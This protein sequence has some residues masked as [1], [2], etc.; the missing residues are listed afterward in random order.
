M[1]IKVPA[2]LQAGGFRDAVGRYGDALLSDEEVQ[3]AWRLQDTG[4]SARHDPRIVV[5]HHI[6]AGRLTPAWLL[7]R[8]YWQGASAVATHRLLGEEAA[9]WHALPRRLAVA[10]LFAPLALVPRT[11]PRLIGPRWRLAFSAGF[12]R[13]ALG[14]HAARAAERIARGTMREAGREPVGAQAAM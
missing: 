4:L 11:S 5:H 1:V 3:L 2:L 12:V 9:V 6:Q 14:W 7:R 8:L 10:A 13:A